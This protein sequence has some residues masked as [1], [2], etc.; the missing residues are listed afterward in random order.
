M[1]RKIIVL[2]EGPVFGLTKS[3]MVN[4]HP[5]RERKQ[6]RVQDKKSILNSAVISL[7]PNIKYMKIGM[8]SDSAVHSHM[9]HCIP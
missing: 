5:K 2:L 4:I 8:K 6:W 3:E 1:V 7:T 9:A